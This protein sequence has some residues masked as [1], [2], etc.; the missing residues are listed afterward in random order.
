MDK[1]MK[2]Q[3]AMLCIT[4]IEICALF[5]GLDGQLFLTSLAAIAGLGGYSIGKVA[6]K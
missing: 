2:I 5:K 6:N 3:I 4:M 1:D